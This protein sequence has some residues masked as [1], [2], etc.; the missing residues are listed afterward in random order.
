L[1]SFS[2]DRVVRASVLEAAAFD[3]PAGELEEHYASAYGIFGS[4]ADKIAVLRFTPEGARWVAD[5]KWHSRQEGEWSPDGRYALRIPYC[6]PRDLVMDIMR[7]GKNVEVVAPESYARGC[8]RSYGKHTPST[9]SELTLRGLVVQRA[10]AS[11]PSEAIGTWLSTVEL[12]LS[13]AK[14]T[15]LSPGAKNLVARNSM[16]LWP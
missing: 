4:K 12:T 6:E 13:I 15:S 16:P 10:L 3:V 8:A 7:Q 2:V 1:R 11:E 5:E 9:Q 14:F